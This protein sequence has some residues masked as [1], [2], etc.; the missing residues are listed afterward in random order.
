MIPN[1]RV[2]IVDANHFIHAEDPK[3]VARLAQDLFEN[4]N[5]NRPD[6]VSFAPVN[7]LYPVKE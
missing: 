3:L 4:R 1:C 2:V 6:K 7:F 5:L